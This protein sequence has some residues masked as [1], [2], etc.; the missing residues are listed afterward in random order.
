MQYTSAERSFSPWFS[1]V[2][3]GFDDQSGVANLYLHYN[4]ITYAWGAPLIRFAQVVEE[5]IMAPLEVRQRLKGDGWTRTAFYGHNRWLF[6]AQ[7]AT[8]MVLDL[9]KE[10]AEAGP[11]V[12]K[13]GPGAWML[14]MYPKSEDGRD[15]D[16]HFPLR[17]TVRAVKGELATLGLGK[18]KVKPDA[19]GRV[20]LAFALAV[21]DIDEGA[22]TGI[23]KSAPRSAKRALEASRCW[24][25]DTLYRLPLPAADR[26]EFLVAA[27]AALSLLM[28]AT[29]APGQL[30]G[31]VVGFPNRGHY[32]C[33]FLW[34]SAFQNLATEYMAPHMAPDALLAL[35]ENLRADGMMAHFLTSTWR[36]PFTSQPPLVGWAAARLVA[37]RK[38]KG[39]A[40]TLL[41]ALAR[42]VEWWMTQRGSPDGLIICRDPMETGWDDTPRLDHG[43]IIALDMTSYVL[44][45]IRACEKLARYIGKR[46][47][48]LRWK[49]AADKMAKALVRRCYDKKENLFFDVSLETGT[50]L[51]LKTPA[52]FLP[53]WAGVPLPET[54]KKKMIRDWL[55]NPAYFYGKIP[56]P[57]VAYD[58]AVYQP[59]KWWRGP[60]WPSVN[61]LLLEMLEQEGMPAERAVI[62]DRFLE[63]WVKDGELREL[64]DSQTGEGLGSYEI[65][66]TAAIFLKLLSEKL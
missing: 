47:E 22:L 36:R 28:N 63:L 43:P 40:A 58:E 59:S 57:S 26:P 45:Q 18:F 46:T 1:E 55:L 21:L 39:L 41:P 37:V 3:L 60:S 54:T 38:D 34:D 15:P 49:V 30:R 4:R 56:F 53:L 29:R 17:L 12:I 48:A 23:V 27:K 19:K 9:G 25:S 24:M 44:N 35:T 51:K 20:L 5:V 8:G 7:G 64:F 31:R 61:Y 42:N 16:T 13:A 50:H 11:T 10:I 66:W 52:A 33:P 14:S 2:G 62:R 65:G 32:A 6:E